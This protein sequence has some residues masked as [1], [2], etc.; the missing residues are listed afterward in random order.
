MS[1]IGTA[2]AIHTYL[3]LNPEGRYVADAEAM[4][5]TLGEAPPSQAEAVVAI[6][7][8]IA[9]QEA[10]AYGTREAYAGYL[11]AFPDGFWRNEARNRRDSLTPPPIG[12]PVEYMPGDEPDY[13][14]ADPER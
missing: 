11:E 6:D 7:D 12:T 1:A 2:E 9:W 3:K 14:P 10:A 13:G 8:A 5:V 4:L